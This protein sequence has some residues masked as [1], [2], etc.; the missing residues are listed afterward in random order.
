M[1][2]GVYVLRFPSGKFYI[3]KAENT[4]T[5][6]QQHITALQK[7]TAAKA[8]QQEYYNSGPP[9]KEEVFRVHADH[10]DLLESILIEKYMSSNQCLNASQPR[11]VPHED[12]VLLTTCLDN[13]TQ[14]TAD[15]LRQL[16]RAL[17]DAKRYK[18]RAK[19]LEKEG[20]VL[21]LEA[22]A[23]LQQLTEDKIQLQAQIDRYKGLSLWDRI[24]N[25][26]E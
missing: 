1:E 20:Y 17:I 10:V 21:P 18:K 7:G 4:T 16:G 14:S 15:H 11:K 23:E 24:F 8:M 2:S 13:L 5:R 12:A 25:Y 22:K 19:K 26:K 6:F 3:G 9:I